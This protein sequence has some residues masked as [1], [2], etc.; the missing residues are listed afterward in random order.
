MCTHS[1]LWFQ[2]RSLHVDKAQNCSHL[3]QFHTS[4][5]RKIKRFN[6]GQICMYVN[7]YFCITSNSHKLLCHHKFHYKSS[8]SLKI[9][10]WVTFT[11]ADEC[12]LGLKMVLN[13]K[14]AHER[15][16]LPKIKGDNYNLRGKKNSPPVNWVVCLLITFWLYYD[17]ILV[18]TVLLVSIETGKLLVLVQGDMLSVTYQ[19]LIQEDITVSQDH[20]QFETNNK[21]PRPLCDMQFII[22][23]VNGKQ[24]LNQFSLMGRI[25]ISVGS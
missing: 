22:Q 17:Q 19:T 5:L 25:E 24:C 6:F 23:D 7:P 8:Q 2:H 16:N 18:C 1:H 20:S 14:R 13:N 15:V 4:C 21:F 3:R 10:L 11:G 9:K 12:C